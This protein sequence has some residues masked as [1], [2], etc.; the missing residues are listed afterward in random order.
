MKV[1]DFMIKDV[2]TVKENTTVKE[3]LEILVSHRIGGVPVIDAENKLVGVISDGDVIRYL[4]PSSQTVFDMFS[5][6]MVSEREKLTDKLQYALEKPVS[7]MMKKKDIKTI[8]PDCEL[9]DALRIFSNYHFK[10][11]PVLD[12]S[13]TVVGVI[14]RG[15]LLRHITNE[16][17]LRNRTL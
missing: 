6:V 10:K 12:D 2:I 1:K 4:K 14:S 7:I 13:K 15:D 17:I 5:I 3:L 16:M 9:D 11:I 8:E